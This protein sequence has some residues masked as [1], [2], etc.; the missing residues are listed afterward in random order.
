MAKGNF[1]DPARQDPLSR[2]GLLKGKLETMGYREVVDELDL[3]EDELGVTVAVND[4]AKLTFVLLGRLSEAPNLVITGK[5][6][7]YPGKG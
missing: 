5:T 3:G 2:I 6:E 7:C 4:N 1:T